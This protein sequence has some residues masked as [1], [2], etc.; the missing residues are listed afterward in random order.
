MVQDE[1]NAYLIYEN[2]KDDVRAK[3]A[4]IQNN[5]CPIEDIHIANIIGDVLCK[6]L[7]FADKF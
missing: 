3:A 7:I 6:R 2:I 1:K 5:R 4:M